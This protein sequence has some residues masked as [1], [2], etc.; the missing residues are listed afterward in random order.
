MHKTWDVYLAKHQ[1]Q[2][3][4]CFVTV[5]KIHKAF[6]P[7]FTPTQF[8]NCKIPVCSV[9]CL[10]IVLNRLSLGIVVTKFIYSAEFEVH[11]KNKCIEMNHLWVIPVTHTTCLK[12]KSHRPFRKTQ[13]CIFQ[14]HRI[15]ITDIRKTFT[16]HTYFCIFSSN[17]LPHQTSILM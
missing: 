10:S 12:L 5:V 1:E 4:T 2:R 9:L 13:Y 11:K 14:E 6:K 7:F 3:K 8:W 15:S 16:E 17:Y